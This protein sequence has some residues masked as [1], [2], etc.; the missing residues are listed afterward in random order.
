MPLSS[1]DIQQPRRPSELAEF[2]E[3][4]RACVRSD[5]VELGAGNTRRGYYKE[6]LDEVVPLSH[7]AAKTYDDCHTVQ[8]ILGNQGYD[9]VV[10]DASGRIVDKVEIANP[11]DGANVAAVAHEKAERGYGSL[12][13][14][15]PGDDVEDLIAIIE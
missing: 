12:K 3:R 4:V 11:I 5:P 8:P 6:F 14:G 1:D 10:R 9:A 15:D 2:V 7:F 13:V